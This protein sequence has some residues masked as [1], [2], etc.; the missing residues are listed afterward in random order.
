MLVLVP[1]YLAS[2][3][4]YCTVA[5]FEFKWTGEAQPSTTTALFLPT[6]QSSRL[7][8]MGRGKCWTRE[9][10]EY[11][12]AQLAVGRT[13]YEISVARGW[14]YASVKKL[15]ATLARGEH[16]GRGGRVGRAA[17]EKYQQLRD[18]LAENP[19][20]S[21]RKLSS[22]AGIPYSTALR[23]IRQGLRPLRRVKCQ[24]LS[25][26]NVAGRFRWC[27]QMRR[28]LRAGGGE[29]RLPGKVAPLRL[30][31]CFLWL[32]FDSEPRAHMLQTSA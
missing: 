17:P 18:S 16:P 24:R 11:V 22:G 5:L 31:Q 25:E 13:A 8:S 27:L 19:Q 6:G 20:Q 23:V 26:Q 28:R 15:R 4:V 21:L 32:P 7:C 2:F 12:R 30:S 10:T 3:H 29:R 1:L 14:P 9:S